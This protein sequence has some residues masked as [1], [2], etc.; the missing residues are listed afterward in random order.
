MQECSVSEDNGKK[1]NR[2]NRF[3]CVFKSQ[4]HFKHVNYFY[5]LMDLYSSC[6]VTFCCTAHGLEE[7]EIQ[8]DLNILNINKYT[9]SK[10]KSQFQLREPVWCSGQ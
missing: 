8:Q 10:V 6:S 5:L 1:V 4:L 2:L 9:P 7:K 3:S